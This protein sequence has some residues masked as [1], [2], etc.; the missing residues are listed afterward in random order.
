MARIFDRVIAEPWLKD[1]IVQKF[2]RGGPGDIRLG[3]PCIVNPGETAVFVRGG[4]SLGTLTSG[5]HVL[6]TA[7]LPLLETIIG[8]AFAGGKTPFTADVYFV[9]TTDMTLKWGTTAPIV[10][11]HLNRPPGASAIIGNG[12]YVVR[13]RDPW[14]FLT[15]MDAFRE[16]V[17]LPQL[18]ERLD[19]M[20]GVMMQDKLS[21][22]ATA[23][24]LGPAQLQSF[25][26]D[27]NDLLVGMLQSDF[28]A[29]GMVLVDF[30]IR[31]GLHPDSL[32]VVTRMGYGTGY[33]QMKT[34]DVGMA[35]AQNPSGGSLGELGIG[36]MGLS[37]I[38][39]QQ[40]MQQQMMAQQQAQQAQQQPQQQQPAAQSGAMPDI[41][42][43]AQ[44]A[45]FVQ[46]TEADIVAAIESGELKA[47]KIGSAYRIT[48][49]ALEAFLGG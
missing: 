8:K 41:M 36:M 15:G 20:L 46:V 43:P 19:P 27:L 2:P 6:T 30:N 17:R 49:A 9:K 32:E 48:K 37:A 14:R 47:R 26:Q 34:L 10:V 28:D 18:K 3:S 35:A 40:A 38:Q 1:E 24:N 31:M 5:T 13:V 21:E 4:E 45:A 11:E 25:S 22:L 42:T 16:S 33:T 29:V 23:K 12:T 7:N 44:A 39:Q